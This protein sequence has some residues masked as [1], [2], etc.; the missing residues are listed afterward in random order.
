MSSSRYNPDMI[1]GSDNEIVEIVSRNINFHVTERTICDFCVNK[2][3]ICFCGW[4][5]HHCD[6]VQ[7]LHNIMMCN[8]EGKM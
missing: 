5:S 2:K 6:R 8:A 7:R 1:F 4:H 3:L